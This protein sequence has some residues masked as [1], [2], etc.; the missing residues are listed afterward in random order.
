[1]SSHK[2]LH[3]GPLFTGFIDDAAVFPPGNAPLGTA[4]ERHRQHRDAWYAP[5]VGPL[6][7]PASALTALTAHLQDDEHLTIG[8][9]AD[10]GPDGAADAIA[11]LP[12]TIA[13]NQIEAR[14]GHDTAIHALARVAADTGIHCYAEIP[15]GTGL[16]ATLDLLGA[17]DLRPKFRTGGLTADLFPTPAALADAITACVRAG[18]DFK[19]TAGLHH[20]LRHTD[21]STGFTHHGF[22][23]ILAATALAASGA[24]P[25]EVARL[26]EITESDPI[27]YSLRG[28]LAHP[29]PHWIG[30]GSCSIAEP[31]DDLIEWSLVDK[32]N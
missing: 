22:G 8:V 27:R 31:L 1:M 12:G 9:I 20:V 30:F 11:D 6:L 13:V 28:M 14:A 4:V 7:L 26:L 3:I 21:P 23:N 10:T 15:L 19:L 17:L 24:E 32:E 5:L 29:R 25:P 18:L 16:P 2:H